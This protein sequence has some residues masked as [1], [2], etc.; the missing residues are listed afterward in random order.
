MLNTLPGHAQFTSDT[1]KGQPRRFAKELHGTLYGRWLL[2]HI[3]LVSSYIRL[4][5]CAG[6]TLGV[7]DV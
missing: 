2:V 6:L 1:G 7:P 3:H 4:V 5:D